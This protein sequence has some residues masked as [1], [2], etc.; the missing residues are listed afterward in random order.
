MASKVGFCPGNVQERLA[1]G[2]QQTTGMVVRNKFIKVK[3]NWL[4]SGEDARCADVHDNVAIYT[5]GRT[6]I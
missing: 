6:E 4:L 5:N 2:T 1:R 3:V